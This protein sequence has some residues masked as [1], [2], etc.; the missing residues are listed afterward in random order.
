MPINFIKETI[1]HRRESNAW[2]SK[3]DAQAPKVGDVAPDF[4]LFDVTGVHRIKLSDFKGK[5]PVAL[6][7][8]SFT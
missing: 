1:K 6:M 2:Q 8:G 5:K 7:F 4:E 3:Y